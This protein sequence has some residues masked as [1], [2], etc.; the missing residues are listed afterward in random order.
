MLTVCSC[1]EDCQQRK[2]GAL[3]EV[4]VEFEC[5]LSGVCIKLDRFCSK[6]RDS[7]YGIRN[8]GPGIESGSEL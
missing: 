3:H 5:E 6:V 2:K 1:D 8:R 7:N 4:V